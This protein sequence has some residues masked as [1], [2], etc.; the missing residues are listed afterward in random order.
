MTASDYFLLITPKVLA[1]RGHPH[2]THYPTEATAT[3]FAPQILAA[4]ERL[5]ERRLTTHCRHST[6]TPEPSGGRLVL[7]ERP[8]QLSGVFA[9]RAAGMY[10]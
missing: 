9:A 7:G 4:R 2:M 5:R 3:G 10:R 8:S 1:E 6:D